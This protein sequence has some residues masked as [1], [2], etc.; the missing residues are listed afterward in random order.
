MT[1]CS[2]Y[3]TYEER[4]EEV[5]EED[6]NIIDTMK[7]VKTRTNNLYIN[8]TGQCLLKKLIRL[9]YWDKVE[10]YPVIKNYAIKLQE[11]Y[12]KA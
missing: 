5:E 3:L 9:S 12:E 6:N 1:P 2:N 11:M 4:E 7:N 8:L 10:T